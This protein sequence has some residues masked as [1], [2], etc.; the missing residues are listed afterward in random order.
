MKKNDL[1]KLVE[2]AS[3]SGLSKPQN[4]AFITYTVADI[5]LNNIPD[6]LDNVLKAPADELKDRIGTVKNEIQTTASFLLSG[7]V[8]NDEDE[9]KNILESEEDDMKKALNSM[10][11]L[12][13]EFGVKKEG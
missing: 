12:D 6:L 5:L 10:C 2:K 11:M 1:V 13:Y 3:K 8:N 4:R 9:V 7:I